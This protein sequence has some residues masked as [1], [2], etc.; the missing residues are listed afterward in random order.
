M[1]K[2]EDALK[3]N[4]NARYISL[5]E[6]ILCYINKKNQLLCYSLK[7]REN[8]DRTRF[9]EVGRLIVVKEKVKTVKVNEKQI[10]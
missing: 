6:P 1:V 4:A 9:I 7:V 5:C 3:I 10:C 2:Q 8:L